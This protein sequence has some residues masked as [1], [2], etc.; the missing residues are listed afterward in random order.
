MTTRVTNATEYRDL[1]ID[2]LVVSPTNPRKTFDEE[3]MKEMAESIRTNGVLQ[4]MLV[5]PRAE[6]QFEIVFG[7]RRYRGAQM[8]GKETVPV[9]IREMTDAQVLEAQLVE[10]LQ[11]RDVHPLEEARGMRALLELDEPKYSIEQIAA[12]T[13]KS[14]AYCAARLR[15]TELAPVA[16]DAFLKDEIGVGHAL[17]LAKLQPAQQ[18]EALAP[19]FREEWS[20][21]NKAKRILLPVRQL[22]GWIE[23]NILLI[24]KD[25]PFS[26][27][28]ARLVPAAG[29]CLECPKRTGFNTLLF[30]GISENSDACSDPACYAA[31][32]DAHVKK[33]VAAKSKLVQITTAHGKP[34]EGSPI[35]P[36]GQYIEIRE[37]KPQNKYQENAL[38]YKT[39]KSV[40]EAIVADGA[41]KGELRKICADPNCHVHR[42]KRQTSRNDAKA[43]QE[44]EKQRHHEAISRAIGL[45]TLE[46]IGN[47]VPVRLMKRELLFIATTMV[48]KLD[49]Q[50]L[51]VIAKLHHLGP[52]K[53]NDPLTKTVLGYLRGIPEG[54][55]GRLIVEMTILLRVSSDQDSNRVLAEAAKEYNIDVASI[56]AVVKKEFADREKAKSAKKTVSKPPSKQQAKEVKKVAAA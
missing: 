9:R 44:Q 54:A 11:R 56:A 28:D 53:E 16:V 52:S 40:T 46:A 47:A 23:Q 49:L 6:R 15:L 30:T 19:C 39:C 50:R 29:S 3:A 2:W 17:L 55:L 12:R 31:K 13:G 37:E 20:S 18:E 1:P 35:V 4:P 43:R 10:N 14:P 25:A 21:G 38:E 42:P 7:E 27:R 32:L 41:D 5:R 33:A 8:A 26:K 48:S 51:E 22:Q 36:R 34:A 45:R 24:L